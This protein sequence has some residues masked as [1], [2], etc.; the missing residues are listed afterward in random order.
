MTDK[1]LFTAIIVAIPTIVGVI[2]KWALNHDIIVRI[3]P[4]SIK[5]ERNGY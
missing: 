5:I 2:T 1:L 4:P 3:W